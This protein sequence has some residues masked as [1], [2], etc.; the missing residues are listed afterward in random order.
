MTFWQIHYIINKAK[1]L[2]DYSTFGDVLSVQFRTLRSG[3][4]KGCI[5]WKEDWRRYKKYSGG[6]II[7][8][9]GPHSIYLVCNALNDWPIAISCISGIL[10]R[11][12]LYETEDTAWITLYFKNDLQVKLDLSWVSKQRNT[13][14]SFFGSRGNIII[15]NNTIIH[16]ENNIVYYDEIISDFDDPSHKEW[17]IDVMKDFYSTVISNCFRWDLL[18]ASFITVAVISAAYES[19]NK[20][21]EI[22]SLPNFPF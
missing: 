18:K 8:D 16:S 6:G 22:I 7:Q 9:H 10:Q 11:N 3:H 20:Q 21:G 1:K 17:F 12:S 14:Y 2:L 19:S 13:Q 4:A 15:E 5:E